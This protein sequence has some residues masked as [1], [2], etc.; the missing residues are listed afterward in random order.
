MIDLAEYYDG[1]EFFNRQEENL[2]VFND[3]DQLFKRKADSLWPM[4]ASVLNCDPSYRT[5]LGLGLFLISLHN[6]DV[7]SDAV[8]SVMDNVF[9][10]ELRAIKNGDIFLCYIITICFFN[11]CL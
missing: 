3:G 6:L 11:L 4:L 1:G 2:L 10:E 7:G 5:K 9:A 8:Q